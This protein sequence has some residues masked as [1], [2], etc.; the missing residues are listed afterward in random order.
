MPGWLATAGGFAASLAALGIGRGDRVDSG[1]PEDVPAYLL[2]VFA[3]ARLGAI[4]MAVNTG[5]RSDEVGDMTGRSRRQGFAAMA[6]IS[7]YSLPGHS[8]R[9]RS[10][11]TLQRLETVILYGEA[12]D[13]PVAA[14]PISHVRT[15]GFGSLLGDAEAPASGGPDD[16]CAIFTTWAPPRRRNS[17]C[18]ASVASPTMPGTWCAAY[19][20]THPIRSRCRRYRSAAS[21][22]SARPWRPWPPA[23]RCICSRCSTPR[24][25]PSC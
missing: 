17:C 8:G 18:T 19:T 24:R 20:S 11:R 4:A 3:C 14:L 1:C 2:T 6:G 12:G 22:G 21:L 16:G 10:G 15:V 23:R 5:C 7:R 13:R 25:R 9:C